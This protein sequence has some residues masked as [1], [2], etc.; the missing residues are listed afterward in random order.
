MLE[1]DKY[2]FWLEIFLFWLLK[3]KK[4][5]LFGVMVVETGSC[6]VAQAGL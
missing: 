1:F 4:L 2:L 6:Y 3:E 5:S